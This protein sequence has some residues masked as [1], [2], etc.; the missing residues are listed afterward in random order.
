MRFK[1]VSRSVTVA[2]TI[3][4]GLV[5]ALASA[6]GGVEAVWAP[7]HVK[8][9]YQGFTT[10]Y[11]CDGLRGEIRRMLARLGARDLKVRPYGCTR[12]VGVEH[13]PGV[14]VTMQVLVPASSPKGRKSGPTIRAHWENVVLMPRSGGLEEQGKCELIEQFKETFLPLF[15]TRHIDYE[16]SCVPHQITLGTHLSAEVLMPDAKPSR[17]R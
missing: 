14:A 10:H 8:F 9:V 11:S 16:S 15:S 12:M 1:A 5:P 2:A 13:F 6:Q 17:G 3:L 7:R 4:L